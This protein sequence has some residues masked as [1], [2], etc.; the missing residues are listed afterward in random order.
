MVRLEN[1]RLVHLGQLRYIVAALLGIATAVGS[2]LNSKTAG[3]AGQS[4]DLGGQ[5]A[6]HRQGLPSR[7]PFDDGLLDFLSARQAACA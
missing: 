7:R 5:H 3:I 4:P 1:D 6:P 2:R